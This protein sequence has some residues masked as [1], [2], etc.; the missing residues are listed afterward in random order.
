MLHI[1]A[2]TDFTLYGVALENSPNFHIVPDNRTPD[3]LTPATCFNPQTVK[4]TDGF[5]PSPAS[6]VLLAYSYISTGEDQVAIKSS[7]SKQSSHDL[8]F[9]HNHFYY[10]QGMSIGSETDAGVSDL[11]VD[12]LVM[13]GF[14]SANSKDLHIK[15]GSNRGR[16]V[17][18]V[19]YRNICMRRMRGPILLDS[20]YGTDIGTKLPHY[21]HL[22]F[23][24]IHSPGQRDFRG[25]YSDVGLLFRLADRTQP[26]QRST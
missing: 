2:G 12:D 5:D 23:K 19:S 20:Y 18:H 4:N 22:V 8:M 25:R 10:G 17:N 9:A 16:L 21:T 1:N 24:Y 3:K 15:S 14:D 26:G 13:D 11:L 6:N 7:R